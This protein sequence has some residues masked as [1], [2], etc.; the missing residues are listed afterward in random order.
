MYKVEYFEIV[1]MI[2][3]GLILKTFFYPTVHGSSQAS[4]S[5]S[6]RHVGVVLSMGFYFLE[7][8]LLESITKR[9]VSGNIKY[10]AN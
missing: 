1:V 7:D 4:L 6:N 9:S 10:S 3:H 8:F 5:R 2:L